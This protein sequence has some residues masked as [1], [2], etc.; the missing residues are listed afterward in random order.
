MFLTWN[1]GFLSLILFLQ[2]RW[3]ED[4]LNDSNPDHQFFIPGFS[5]QVPSNVLPDAS[6]NKDG[7]YFAYYIN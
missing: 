7:G 5:N 2:K 3:I 6:F 4:V 1:V